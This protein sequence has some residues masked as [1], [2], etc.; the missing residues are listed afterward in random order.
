MPYGLCHFLSNPLLEGWQRLTMRWLRC[1][2]R[3]ICTGLRFRK[4]SAGFRVPLGFQRG[5]LMPRYVLKK[6]GFL[7][8]QAS[9]I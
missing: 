8:T 5:L 2:H 6:D 4:I 3:L 1:C 9:H 7:I